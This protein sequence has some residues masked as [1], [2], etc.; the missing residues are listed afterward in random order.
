M[1]RGGQSLLKAPRPRAAT[2]S[3]ACSPF[4]GSEL[5]ISPTPRDPR[6]HDA[7]RVTPARLGPPLD[8][9]L[10]GDGHERLTRRSPGAGRGRTRAAGSAGLA[11]RRLSACAIPPGLGGLRGP[12]GFGRAHPSRLNPGRCAAGSRPAD[13]WGPREPSRLPGPAISDLWNAWRA[14]ATVQQDRRFQQRDQDWRPDPSG[15][16]WPVPAPTFEHSGNVLVRQPI[17]K[18]DRFPSDQERAL[19]PTRLWALA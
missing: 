15:Q 7:G 19:A 1:A 12:Q 17:T 3:A 14:P 10:E 4:W 6:G 8:Q 16:R 9:C 5:A 13:G 2:N 11:C 18:I